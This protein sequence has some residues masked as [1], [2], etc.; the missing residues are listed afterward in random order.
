MKIGSTSSLIIFC[1]A[2]SFLFGSDDVSE[3]R[4]K[5]EQGNA[6]A[7]AA[8]GFIYQNGDG[9][10]KDDSESVRWYRKAAE[11]GNAEAQ[12]ALGFIY[13]IGDGVPKDELE[14]LKWFT[15]AAEQGHAGAQNVLG[16]FYKFGKGV[17]KDYVEAYKWFNLAAAQG[18]ESAA[19]ARSAMAEIMTREQIAEAQKLSRMWKPTE[20]NAK[21][22]PKP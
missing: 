2:S 7:Q 4:I 10:P 13:Q 21:S 9:V 18:K 17:P 8:L 19:K 11:Q 1:L 16:L 20:S 6:D 14:S 22:N 5:A 3:I 12:A 15:K